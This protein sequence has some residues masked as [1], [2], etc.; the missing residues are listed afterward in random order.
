[1]PVVT[2]K[3][4]SLE[5]HVEVKP[6]FSIVYGYPMRLRGEA[7]H[8]WD[9]VQVSMVCGALA[10]EFADFDRFQILRTVHGVAQYIDPSDG[11]DGLRAAARLSL[12]VKQSRLRRRRTA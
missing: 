11:S 5:T 10:R 3:S 1:M 12:A 2:G 8:A 6:S 9:P 4:P 7:P